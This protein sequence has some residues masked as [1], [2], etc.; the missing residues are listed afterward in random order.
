M[1][2][3]KEIFSGEAILWQAIHFVG[4]YRNK[5]PLVRSHISSEKDSRRIVEA[6]LRNIGYDGCNENIGPA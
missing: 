5:L 6:L 3:F 1:A 2:F 4:N